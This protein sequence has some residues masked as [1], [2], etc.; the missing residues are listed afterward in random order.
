[1]LPGTPAF[2]SCTLRHYGGE[3]AAHAHDHAQ[4]LV[5]LQGRMELEVDGRAA[6]VD[7]SCGILIPAGVRHGYLASAGARFCVV[8]A[9]AQPGMDRLR[10][11]AVPAQARD[12]LARALGGGA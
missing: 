11:F 12:G 3:H 6:F 5:G 7:A 10:R 2:L 4:V 8:D 1:M 9:A